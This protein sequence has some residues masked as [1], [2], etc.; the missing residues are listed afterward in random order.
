MTI[1]QAVSAVM[2]AKG[3]PLSPAE[4]YTAV[5][6]ANLYKFNTDDPISIVRTQIRRR[7]ID[8]DFP[9]AVPRKVFK[10]SNDG[11]YELFLP[12]SEPNP[13]PSS[14]VQSRF[15]QL[16]NLQEEHDN[17]VRARA[18]DA[19]KS[20]SPRAFERF[21]ERLL[22]AYGFE[23]VTVTRRSRDGGIDGTGRLPIGLTSISVAFQCKRYSSKSVGREAIDAFRGATSGLHEQ[24]FFFTTSRFTLEAIEVQRRPGAV[25]IALFDGEKIVDIMFEKSF[26]ISF[27][28]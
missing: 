20:L 6:E 16:C 2:R 7:C 14:P 17:E 22:T 18:L 23:E 8:L 11:R 28:E 25:P 26:G 10:T 15:Q 24:G 5:I 27:N 1:V 3:R 13:S 19:L 9:S 12:N 21:A 4:A